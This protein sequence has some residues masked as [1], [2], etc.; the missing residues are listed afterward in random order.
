MSVLKKTA[1]VF[2]AFAVSVVMFPGMLLRGWRSR[3]ACQPL[4]QETITQADL[5]A[6]IS[7]LP[8]QIRGRFETPAGRQQLLDQVVLISLLS[9]EARTLGIDKQDAVARKIK[10]MTDNI[11]VQELTRQKVPGDITVS[12]D[13]IA[14]YY[15]ENKKDFVREEQVNVSLIMFAMPDN[16]TSDEKDEKKEAGR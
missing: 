14:A 12:D 1:Y 3:S 15:Q 16:I 2:V 7:M 6:R 5:D 13:E 8:P 10:E 11:I 4:V 9:Q